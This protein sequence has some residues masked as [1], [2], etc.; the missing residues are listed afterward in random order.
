MKESPVPFTP[1]P[2]PQVFVPTEVCSDG[3]L[4]IYFLVV[5]M[6]IIHRALQGE[7]ETA[8]YKLLLASRVVL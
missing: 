4:L 6:L 7:F 2:P 1:F 5:M 8:F 3:N